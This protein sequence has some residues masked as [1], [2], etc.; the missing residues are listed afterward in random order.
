M[1]KSFKSGTLVSLIENSTKNGPWGVKI[2]LS[3]SPVIPL[4]CGIIGVILPPNKGCEIT[5]GYRT[6]FLAEEKQILE[7][8][9][10]FL[11]ELIDID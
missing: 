6:V 1:A 9:E 4:K 11:E 5:L 2:S 8:P 7:I 10:S 3:N